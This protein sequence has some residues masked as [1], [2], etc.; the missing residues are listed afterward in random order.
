[1]IEND[2]SLNYVG[3]KRRYHIMSRDWIANEIFRR[4]EPSGN[5]MGETLRELRY[6]YNI[7]IIC[8]AKEE[9]L[10]DLLPW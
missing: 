7:D 10:K 1:M 9:E 4:V 6:R 3:F 8:G 2:I 5:T